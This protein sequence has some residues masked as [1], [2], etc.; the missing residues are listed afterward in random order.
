M[1]VVNASN[2]EKDWRLHEDTRVAR[3]FDCEFPTSVTIQPPGVA[4]SDRQNVC[5]RRSRP[6]NWMQSPTITSSKGGCGGSG[7]H[8]TDR[9]HRRGRVRALRGARDA[10]PLWH[11]LT[12]SRDP[13][14]IVTPTGLGA[15]DSLR[16]EMG[17]ALYGNDIDDAVTPLEANLG[18]VVK[19]RKGDFVGRDALLAQR[20][21]GVPCKLVGF[22]TTERVFP[23]RA[24]PS[25]SPERPRPGAE[26][27]YRPDVGVGI[28]TAYLPTAK[29]RRDRDRDRRA[30][31]RIPATVVRCPFTAREVISDPPGTA[32]VPRLLTFDLC[33]MTSE[34]VDTSLTDD[35]SFVPRHIGPRDEDVSAMARLLGYDSVDALI[36]ATVPQSIRLRRPLA[37]GPGR[38]EIDAL[39]TFRQVAERN[40]V[41]RS[42]IGLGYYTC[43]TPPVIQRNI[44][45]NPGWYTAYTPYQAEVAQGGWRRC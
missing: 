8:F 21:A 18:W 39:R 30:G 14:L 20:A 4:R 34:S 24:I 11:A 9:L 2:R 10:V 45:E 28:G 27:H 17:M 5:C 22:T 16:L 26:W 7:R 41:F 13:S 38:S 36:D 35:G 23:V 15:R 42:F 6:R 37:L 12:S 44:L 19:T 40:E 32:G 29:P 31:Q 1:L 33:P 3:R 25:I 43:L